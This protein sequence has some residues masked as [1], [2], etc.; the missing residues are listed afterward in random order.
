[1][2]DQYQRGLL[3]PTGGPEQIDILVTDMAFN[4]LA[5]TDV[6]YVVQAYCIQYVRQRRKYTSFHPMGGK[7]LTGTAE[8]ANVMRRL[9]CWLPDRCHRMTTH[10]AAVE[11]RCC[12]VS[13][14]AALSCSITAELLA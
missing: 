13:V 10:R 6:I 14:A 5:A 3:G 9:A 8:Y 1:M 12:G 7:A 2:S 4:T 11:G